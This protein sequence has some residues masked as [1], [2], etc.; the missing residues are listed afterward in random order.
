MVRL[1]CFDGFRLG[2]QFKPAKNNIKPPGLKRFFKYEQYIYY[3]W[4][5][6]KEGK[7]MVTKWLN[8]DYLICLDGF[9]QV[10]GIY[11]AG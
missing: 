4:T 10:L 6:G 2:N 8:G 11:Q 3:P 5:E 1:I 7:V 9:R